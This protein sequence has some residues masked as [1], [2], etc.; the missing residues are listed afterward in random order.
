VSN[1]VFFK[2]LIRR[3]ILRRIVCERFSES[4]AINALSLIS[5]FLGFRARVFFDT[6]IR[7]NNAASMLRAA[8]LAKELGYKRVTAIEFGVAAGAGLLNMA[9]IARRVTRLTGVEFDIYGF[10]TGVGMPRPIDYRDHPEIY[11]QGD[12]KM[13]FVTLNERLPKNCRLLIGNT[14]ETVAKLELSP[15]SPIGYIVL[16]VDYYSSSVPCLRI[17]ERD[18]KFYLPQVF[19]YADDVSGEPMN[20]WCGE[21]LA[22]AEFNDAHALRKI[23]PFKSLVY[24]RPCKQG[25]WLERMFVAHIL[26]SPFRSSSFKRDFVKQEV[27]PYM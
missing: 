4:F 13:N 16:D 17:L 9:S 25:S 2:K 5:L 27:N 20:P 26:D 1:L 10:D 12:F 21:Q 7:P 11:S 14:E 6:V 22:I 15:G 18:P 3:D 23:A 24:Y 19:M 8:D